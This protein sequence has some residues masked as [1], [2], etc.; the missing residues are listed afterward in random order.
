MSCS[1]R[2]VCVERLG[3][4]VWECRSRSPPPLHTP[5]AAARC[6][7]PSEAAPSSLDTEGNKVIQTHL[8]A[9]M[10]ALH[11]Q[12]GWTTAGSK[13]RAAHLWIEH[14]FIFLKSLHSGFFC[15]MFKSKWCRL[16][17][18]LFEPL[19]NSKYQNYSD[20]NY[21]YK[22]SSLPFSERQL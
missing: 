10:T 15:Y 2:R 13:C 8:T 9:Q 5:P 12:G 7:S 3:E 4:A 1:P 21:R 19:I 20:R 16:G 14:L 17:K 22:F 18:T 11:G 6:C